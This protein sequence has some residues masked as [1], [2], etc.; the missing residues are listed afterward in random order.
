MKNIIQK[1]KQYKKQLI[2]VMIIA[3]PIFIIVLAILTNKKKD[4]SNVP[5]LIIV[6]ESTNNLSARSMS[7]IAANPPSGTRQTGDFL[8]VADFTFTMEID[9]KSVEIESEPA[10]DFNISVYGQRPNIMRIEAKNG[11]RSNVN[12]NITIKGVASVS[13]ETIDKPIYYNYYNDYI[14]MMKNI[15]PESFP[16]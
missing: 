9:P 16:D 8:K 4:S 3:L 1:L 5:P 13:G 11:L 12:Y 6:N 7:F 10:L 2:A 15:P 14:T